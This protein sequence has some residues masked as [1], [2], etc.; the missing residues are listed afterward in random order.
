MP[1]IRKP[2]EVTGRAGDGAGVAGGSVAFT[3]C[4]LVPLCLTPILAAA[5]LLGVFRAAATE[6]S[7]RH[8]T[9]RGTEQL[10]PAAEGLIRRQSLGLFSISDKQEDRHGAGS[11]NISF[12]D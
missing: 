7:P 9:D 4:R 1:T 2:G 11:S 8:D 12:Q 6:S 3:G 5:V 10:S